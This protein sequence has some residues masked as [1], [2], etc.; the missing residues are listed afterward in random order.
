MAHLMLVGGTQRV[1]GAFDRDHE[2]LYEAGVA[3]VLDTDTGALREILR[4]RDEPRVCGGEPEAVGHCLKGISRDGGQWLVNTE[5]NLLWM[6]GRGHVS[7]D[8]SD[9][10]LNDVHHALRCGDRLWV[11]STGMD[12]VLEVITYNALKRACEKWKQAEGALEVF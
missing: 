6:D 2:R 10:R 1:A 5:R 11:A 12:A 9:P 8:W 3:A 4:H 7:R